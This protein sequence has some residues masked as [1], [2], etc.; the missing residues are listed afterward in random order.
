MAKRR[1]EE[2]LEKLNEKL[3]E[4]YLR[5]ENAWL[6]AEEAK[7]FS[8]SLIQSISPDGLLV[9]ADGEKIIECNNALEEIFGYSMDE[10]IGKSVDILFKDKFGEFRNQMYEA[11]EEKGY[12]VTEFWTK[13][14]S[15]EKLALELSF[16]GLKDNAG[17]VTVVRDITDRKEAEEGLKRVN[18]DLEDFAFTVSHDLKT[19]LQTILGFSYLLMEDYGDKLGES[20]KEYIEKLIEG[21]SQMERL[22]NDLLKLSRVGRKYAEI[23][24]V[25]L[26]E[27]VEEIKLDLGAE[28]KER[29]ERIV[30]SD[31]PKIRT[32]RTWI[33]EL[34]LNLISNGLKYNESETPT[35]EIGYEEDEGEY[36]FKIR[37]N[38]IG[39]E[40][41]NY[42][43]IFK[44]FERV[45]P[46]SKYEGTGAG[47]AICKK[48]IE[49]IGGKI[50]VE[51]E[52]GRGTTFYF[53]I[54]KIKVE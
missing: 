1:A 11:I 18:Q 6:I 48:I 13:K 16:A 14:R 46:Y 38:G 45:D 53:S 2:E 21:A 8:E 51:S 24:I 7:S 35:V 12:Y 20:G 39:I 43:K 22:I 50:W 37:D 5:A 29:N 40:R 33:K 41:E 34:F 17:L 44:I 36:R 52:P 4:A 49:S 3:E 26:N 23:E 30:S 27:V 15:G 54:S 10:L 25:D 42:E 31:L 9:I 28:I 19:P 47:L 32:Q